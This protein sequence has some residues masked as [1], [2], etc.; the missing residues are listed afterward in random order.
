MPFNIPLAPSQ[1]LLSGLNS[2]FLPKLAVENPQNLS[3]TR[4][5]CP[6]QISPSPAAQYYSDS[7]TESPYTESPQSAPHS[8]SNITPSSHDKRWPGDVGMQYESLSLP[9]SLGWPLLPFKPFDT[10]SW[11][12]MILCALESDA[13]AAHS[14]ASKP[15]FFHPLCC[16]SPPSLLPTSGRSSPAS[17]RSSSPASSR[18]GSGDITSDKVCSHCNTMRTP[19]WRREPVTNRP[20]CNACGVY[21]QQ[22]KKMRP[23]VLMLIQ[24]ENDADKPGGP[25]CSHCHTHRTSVWR[26]SRIGAKLCNACGVY[27]RLHGFDRPLALRKDKVGRRGEHPK[28]MQS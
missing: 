25:E 14:P 15:H 20:L 8:Y 17:G 4:A 26:R 10:E 27:E 9:T 13:V 2:A 28:R 3:F 19:L 5:G 11:N 7:S 23:A 22:R 16:P 21:L 24:C 1:P 6:D 18:L 12:E